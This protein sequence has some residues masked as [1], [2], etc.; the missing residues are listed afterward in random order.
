MNADA[1]SAIGGPMNPTATQGDIAETM[2]A[3]GIAPHD[4]EVTLP[5]DD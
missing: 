1:G 3:L 2:R 4:V 5:V